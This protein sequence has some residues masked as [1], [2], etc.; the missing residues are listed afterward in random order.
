MAIVKF[1]TPRLR[2][3]QIS[4]RAPARRCQ[5]LA[6]LQR[7]AAKW[8]N[9]PPRER[10]WRLDLTRRKPETSRI[11]D[12]RFRKYKSAAMKHNRSVA[13]L[14]AFALIPFACGGLAAIA[15]WP[16]FR[17]PA[18]DGHASPGNNKA[19]GLPLHWS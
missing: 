8:C 14:A 13:F 10:F 11:I 1:G 7:I 18:G 6:A 5:P 12:L 4:V 15:E 19:A 17:G 2:R 9:T 16:E 3:W